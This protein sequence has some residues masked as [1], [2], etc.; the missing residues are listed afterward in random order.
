MADHS[1]P[2]TGIPRCLTRAI[3]GEQT[4]FDRQ[5]GHC[6][7]AWTK[8]IEFQIERV[9]SHPGKPQGIDGIV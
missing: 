9:S 1:G 8:H 5:A 6:G 7:P 2:H 3:L 4:V